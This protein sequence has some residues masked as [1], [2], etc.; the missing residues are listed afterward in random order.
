MMAQNSD[1]LQLDTSRSLAARYFCSRYSREERYLKI[2]ERDFSA[3]LKSS[4]WLQ[5]DAAKEC[6]KYFDFLLD[7]EDL[8]AKM[9][10]FRWSSDFLLANGINFS[11]IRKL[12]FAVA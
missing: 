4:E 11:E 5:S 12:Y 10:E 7:F 6:Q 1:R 9:K 3:Y 2:F 8:K